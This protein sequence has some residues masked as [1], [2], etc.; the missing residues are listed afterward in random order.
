MTNKSCKRPNG[1]TLVGVLVILAILVVLIAV[2]MPS[3]RRAPEAAYRMACRNNMRQIALAML[4]YEKKHGQFP[5]AYTVDENGQRLHSWRT[6]ILP[7]MELEHLY[8]KIDLSKPW[9]HPVN[10]AASAKTP[11]CYKCPSHRELDAGMTSYCAIVAE[12]SVLQPK[13]SSSYRDIKDDPSSTA[14]VFESDMS[15]QIHWMSPYDADWGELVQN[16]QTSKTAHSIGFRHVGFA[17]G[18]IAWFSRETTPQVMID[19]ATKNG[20]EKIPHEFGM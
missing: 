20:G 10:K 15:A 2:F 16:L 6:L 13:N 4:N 8:Q 18:S 14:M 17:D 5:P 3:G 11:N 1:F 7:Y 9:D 19:C 12:D